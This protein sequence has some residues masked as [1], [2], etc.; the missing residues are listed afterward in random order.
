MAA[1]MRKEAKPT[2]DLQVCIT[3]HVHDRII[4]MAAQLTMHIK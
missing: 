1:D 4:N 3:L 2:L